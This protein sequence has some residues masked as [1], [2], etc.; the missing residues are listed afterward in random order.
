[1]LYIDELGNMCSSCV[2]IKNIQ[3]ISYARP[4]KRKRGENTSKKLKISLSRKQLAIKKIEDRY[5]EDYDILEQIYSQRYHFQNGFWE[6]RFEDPNHRL[7]FFL[8]NLGQLKNPYVH[9]RW[10]YDY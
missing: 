4:P 9:A 6:N 1:M 7:T 3:P 5:N 10:D 8:I 2:I